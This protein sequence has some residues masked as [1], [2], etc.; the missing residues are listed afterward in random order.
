MSI[1]HANTYIL[2][3]ILPCFYKYEN[4][5]YKNGDILSPFLSHLYYIFLRYSLG[6]QPVY[7]LKVIP[8]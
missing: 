2:L 1:K 7:S 8:K 5:K 3:G 6:V 4:P